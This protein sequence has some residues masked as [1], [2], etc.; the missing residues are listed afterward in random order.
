[1]GWPAAGVDS[2]GDLLIVYSLG[3]PAPG[4]ALLL[5]V[6]LLGGALA[7]TLLSNHEASYSLMTAIP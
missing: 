3:P 6:P 7:Q 2:L 4:T 1:V 5:R